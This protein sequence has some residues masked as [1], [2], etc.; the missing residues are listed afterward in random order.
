[1]SKKRISTIISI[2]ILFYSML[3]YVTFNS[4]SLENKKK[5]NFQNQG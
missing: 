2:I 3:I 5:I 1:M 4:I